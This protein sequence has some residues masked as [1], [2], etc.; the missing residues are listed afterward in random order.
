MENC[1]VKIKVPTTGV[2]DFPSLILAGEGKYVDKTE[3][4]YQLAAHRKGGGDAVPPCISAS[5][6]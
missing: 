2:F 5:P 3:L 6:H 4:L 1:G